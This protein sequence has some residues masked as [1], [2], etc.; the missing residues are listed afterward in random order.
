MTICSLFLLF[1]L[2]F[3]A[4]QANSS[5]INFDFY[6]HI[7]FNRLSIN[8]GLSQNLVSTIHQDKLGFI[9]IGTMDGL[10]MY[11]GYSF[12]I[13]K[14]NPF[15]P[16]SLSDNFIKAIFCDSRGR[17]WVGTHTGGLNLYD[18]DN[19]RFIRFMHNPQD[20][21]TIGAN[22]ILSI[23]D[24]KYGNIWVGTSGGGLNRI[25]FSNDELIP[26]IEDI[27]IARFTNEDDDKSIN[28]HGVTSL[29]IDKNDIL[30]IGTHQGVFAYSIDSEDTFFRQIPL[31]MNTSDSANPM[32]HFNFADGRV[33]IFDDHE[34]E[35]WMF[36]RPG[37]FKYDSGSGVFEQ[38]QF[39]YHLDLVNRNSYNP[40]A[41]LSFKN[42]DITEFWLSSERGLTVYFPDTG[43]YFELPQ[44]NDNLS[45]LPEGN[46]IS[47]YVD[48]SGTMWIGSNGYGLAIYDPYKQ[49][50]NYPMETGFNADG[51]QISSRRLSLRSIYETDDGFLWLGANQGF[52]RVNRMTSEISEV[53]IDASDITRNLV[54]YSIESDKNGIL[55]LASA[56]GLVRFNPVTMTYDIYSAWHSDESESDDPRVSRVFFQNEDIWVLT[57]YGLALFDKQTGKFEHF[58]YTNEPLDR[59]R[60]MVFPYAYIDRKGDFWLGTHQGFHFFDKRNKDFVHYSNDPHNLHS[61]P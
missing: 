31:K 15:D 9:W 26:S 29:F 50:F 38:D 44:N 41:A 51:E 43:K 37:L 17:L 59:Y 56:A 16:T 60:D 57:P 14:H 27:K 47:A 32:T 39:D 34:G 18:R 7:S 40:H 13:Y 58:R 46:L 2:V 4:T 54:V 11:D 20:E 33:I 8:D 53:L 55:W 30:W 48:K 24:D 49:K 45:G 1:L 35:I 19:D 36:G 5:N 6:S 61:L 23:I 21:N 42:K 25:S 52:F 3:Y 12:R 28:S 22:F 10:N